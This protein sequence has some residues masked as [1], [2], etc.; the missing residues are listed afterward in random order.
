M[1]AATWVVLVPGAAHT[2]ATVVPGAGASKRATSIEASSCTAKLPSAKARHSPGAPPGPTTSP[3]GARRVDRPA[4]PSSAARRAASASRVIR[5]VFVR[6][7][8]GGRSF[9]AR[10]SASASSRP[11]LATH[12]STSHVGNEQRVASASLGSRGGAGSRSRAPRR[13][14]DRSTALTKAL[15]PGVRGA[16]VTAS[17]TAANAGTR[18]RNA[19]WY[20]VIRRITRTRGSSDSSR[21]REC[22][23]RTQSR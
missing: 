18:S 12:R 6:N 22:G 2:S 20:A 3:S 9:R 8:R 7:V 10:I 5:S 21:R 1:S 15:T 4:S 17:L 16:S 19:I 11:Y 14:K 23:A 13:E